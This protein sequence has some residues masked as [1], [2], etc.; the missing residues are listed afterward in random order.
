M[1]FDPAADALLLSRTVFTALP[2]GALA[3]EAFRAGA[4]LSVAE[5]PQD[6][7]LYDTTS[8]ALYHDP[9]G[10]GVKAALRIA[11]LVGAPALGVED[12]L[13]G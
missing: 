6:R 11:V 12:I 2:A 9:D 1:D 5:S 10:S 3:P 13:V 8:G 7:I 4:G